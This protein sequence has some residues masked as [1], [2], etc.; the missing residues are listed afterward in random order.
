[1]SASREFVSRART[2]PRTTRTPARLAPAAFVAALAFASLTSCEVLSDDDDPDLP[3]FARFEALVRA[4]PLD[5]P[6][7]T[8]AGRAST[9]P[10]AYVV[11]WT[12][13]TGASRTDTVRAARLRFLPEFTAATE[14]EII[15]P[16][17][18]PKVGVYRESRIEAGRPPL[19]FQ[20]LYSPDGACRYAR[21]NGTTE[22]LTAEADHVAGRFDLELG[23]LTR[24]RD[25][26]AVTTCP[27][28]PQ[29]IRITGTFDA[30]VTP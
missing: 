27:G 22:I 24:V 4:A 1:M 25:G 5:T 23:A 14:M 18:E 29:H 9:A 26:Q 19:R 11:A 6:L 7:D 12:D 16:D 13:G 21:L 15:L 2:A 8:L 20:A 30:E 17:P 3:A 10:Y 28:A